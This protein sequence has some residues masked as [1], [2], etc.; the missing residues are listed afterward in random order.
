MRI[1]EGNGSGS[2]TN[3]VVGWAAGPYRDLPPTGEWNGRAHA[4][5]F[6][7]DNGPGAGAP[8]QTNDPSLVVNFLIK[9]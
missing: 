8:L 3:H 5:G 6:V 2:E 7:T 4:H 1:V 9:L